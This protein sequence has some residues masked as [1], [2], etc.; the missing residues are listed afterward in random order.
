MCPNKRIVMVIP[1]LK[2][3]GAERVVLTLAAGFKKFNCE[4]H[5]VLF[6]K[7]IE[8]ETE[9]KIK[10]H[11]FSRYYRWVPKP[12][13][14]FVLAP[15]L[16][17]FI[18]QH[19]GKPDLVLSNLL[20]ADILMAYSKYNAYFIIHSHMSKEMISFNRDKNFISKIYS[21]K[22]TVSVSKGVKK[23]FDDLFDPYYDSY[24]IYSPVDIDLIENGSK[25]FTPDI[26]EY[27]VHVGNFN[28]AKRH[29]I[30]IKAYHKSSV[31][32]PLLLVGQGSLLEQSKA[33]V[34]NLGIED[35]VMFA[36]F[37]SNPY[38]YIKHAKF[39]VLSSDFEGLPTVILEALALE[40][41]II[42]TDC[43]SGPSE[44]LPQKNLCE[45]GNIDKL[46]KLIQ[47]ADANPEEY[48]THLKDE[49]LLDSAIQKYLSLI[50]K[51]QLIQ[52]V[53]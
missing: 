1:D 36:G 44:I 53:K 20:P 15:L 38:P 9:E 11:V 25:Q 32:T 45:V 4:V 39:I 47:N 29:D 30:L 2:G 49:F 24:Q 31:A 52:E 14:G 46:S 16:D 37:K 40:T 50:K 12:I 34:K 13:R 19:C 10:I 27:I 51:D 7:F 23:D 35:K 42:S 6:N 33:L 43:Q 22:P 41:P 28:K 5:I 3:N 26:S 8:F 48:K 17:K 18:L 21:K